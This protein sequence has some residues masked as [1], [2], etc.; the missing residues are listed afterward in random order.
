MPQILQRS[1]MPHPDTV[2]GKYLLSG[3]FT[4]PLLFLHLQFL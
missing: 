4:V 2:L 1:T 3:I